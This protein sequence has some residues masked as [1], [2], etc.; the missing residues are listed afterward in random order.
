MK[1]PI[2][3]WEQLIALKPQRGNRIATQTRLQD[4]CTAALM[5]E[6]SPAVRRKIRGKHGHQHKPEMVP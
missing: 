3:R 5:A 6:L 1:S 2:K 4:A